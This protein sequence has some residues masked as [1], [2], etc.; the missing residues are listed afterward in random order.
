MLGLG[1]G[2]LGVTRSYVVEQTEIGVE[3]TNML[4]RLTA[5]QY[6]G[7]AATPFLGSILVVLDESFTKSKNSYDF[8]AY[9]VATLAALTLISMFYP[10]K[11]IEE[12]ENMKMKSHEHDSPN[13]MEEHPLLIELKAME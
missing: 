3:R 10:F 6:A 9:F 11:N 13:H 7:F 2:S 12:I 5:L 1:S 4:A 8:P